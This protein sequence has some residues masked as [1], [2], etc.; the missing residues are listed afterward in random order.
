M[1]SHRPGIWRRWRPRSD[2]ALG[3]PSIA[4]E[5]LLR[6]P[7]QPALPG[8]H[9]AARVYQTRTEEALLETIAGVVRL[10]SARG[11][12]RGRDP[13]GRSAC[14]STPWRAAS[15]RAASSSTSTS[16]TS[17]SRCTPGR[18]YPEAVFRGVAGDFTQGST[19]WGPAAV[20]WWPCSAARSATSTAGGPDPSAGRRASRRRR[21]VPA[22]RG[23]RQGHACWRPRTTTRPA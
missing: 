13:G 15:S 7:R 6:R 18:D 5:V 3:R 8:D 11:R 10:A 19:A 23:P 12:R 22:R 21:R 1:T 4:L 9:P 14:S 16:A 20:A 2:T 17:S